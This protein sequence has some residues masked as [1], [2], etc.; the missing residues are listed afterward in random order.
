MNMSHMFDNLYE[1]SSILAQNTSKN[2]F[3]YEDIF[4][5][6]KD[7][8]IITELAADFEFAILG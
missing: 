6:S 8:F 2:Y 1:W 3:S 4:R 7:R 5:K